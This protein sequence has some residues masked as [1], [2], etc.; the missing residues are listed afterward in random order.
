[1]RQM[2]Q[3]NIA[4]RRCYYQ[5]IDQVKTLRNTSCAVRCTLLNYNTTHNVNQR[6]L[7]RLFEGDIKTDI[8]NSTY[9]SISKK[10][11]DTKSIF[12]SLGLFLIKVIDNLISNCLITLKINH[13]DMGRQV[14]DLYTNLLKILR[15][16][17]LKH[18]FLSLID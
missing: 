2:T 9:C 8:L 13:R 11:F 10:H 4:F 7:M 3:I 5:V 17:G 16:I 12:I 18:N 15:T 14:I 6:E 1:M